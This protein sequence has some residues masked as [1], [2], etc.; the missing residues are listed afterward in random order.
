[1]ETGKRPRQ[2]IPNEQVDDDHQEEEEV[3]K[4]TCQKRR[5][6]FRNTKLSPNNKPHNETVVVSWAASSNRHC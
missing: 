4:T 5:N 2:R 3:E 6:L 1:M